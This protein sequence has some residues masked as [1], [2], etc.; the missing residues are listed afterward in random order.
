M[1]HLFVAVTAHG[2]GHL[3]QVAPVVTELKRR[4]PDLEISLQGNIAPAFAN[5][6]LPAGY[7]HIPLA[8]DVPLPMDGPLTT[9]WAEGL[10][11]YAA[12]DLDYPAHLAQQRRLFE[13]TRPDLVLA[14]IPWLP[15]DVARSMG[16][17]CAGLCSLSWYDILAE[18]PVGDQLPTA[19]ARRMQR[20]YGGADLFLRPAPSMPMSWL[21]NGRDIGPIAQPFARD[22]LRLHE[23]FGRPVTEQL[24]LMQFGG[25]GRLQLGGGPHLMDGVHL[26][27]PD[28]DAGRGRDDLTLI[29]ADG[30]S[31]LEVLASCDALITKPGYGTFAEAA[32]NGIPVLSVERQ[33]WPESR[34]LVDWLAQQV[35]LREISARDFAAGQI[36]EPLAELLA[37]GIAEPVA[38]TGVAEAAELLIDLLIDLL[39]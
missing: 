31:V 24:V 35:P 26:L 6:R 8:A 7:H 5:A 4:L 12:F 20:A 14:D 19:L 39:Q 18:S 25:T 1:P 33:D 10:A 23:R 2:Y 3:A 16:I 15:L 9:R 13:Q 30:N 11:D 28:A 21:P 17:P 37:E 32:C 22:P 34:W 27:S 29:D 38:P 36:H